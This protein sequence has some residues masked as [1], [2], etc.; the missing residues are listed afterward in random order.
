MRQSMSKVHE[1]EKKMI[2][3]LKMMVAHWV[4]TLVL[5]LGDYKERHLNVSAASISFYAILSVFPLLAFLVYL[6]SQVQGGGGSTASAEVVLRILRDWVPGMAGWIEKGLFSLMRGTAVANAINGL[7]L[8]WAG[9]GLF[10]AL[11]AV[12][13]HLPRHEH[14]HGEGLSHTGRFALAGATFTLFVV[15]AA[16]VIVCELMG[17]GH[18][19]SS[20]PWLKQLPGFVRTAL[21]AGAKSGVILAV[22]GVAVCTALYRLLL[23]FRLSLRNAALGGAF[24]AISLAL[25]KKVYW[26]YM[27][28]SGGELAATYGVFSTL[29]AIILWVHFIVN[30]GVIGGLFAYHLQLGDGGA[31]KGG[32]HSGGH[33]GHGGGHSVRVIVGGH[34][35]GS[36]GGTPGSGHGG[37][38][39]A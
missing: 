10:T 12:M 22:V 13:E 23:P 1:V 29:V 35:S 11:Q 24:F 26:V 25:S 3:G 31:A 33:S 39:A 14:V 28:K 9:W 8:A 37:S 21:T 18:G 32:G 6:A 2:G 20:L 38:H 4:R 34:G 5:A 16:T 15:L 17:H 19:A 27:H 30:C 7:V 36:H